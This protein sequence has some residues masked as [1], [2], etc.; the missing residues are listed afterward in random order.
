MRVDRRA[1][2]ISGVLVLVLTVSCFWSAANLAR[3][4][5]PAFENCGC[6]LPSPT[7]YVL[8]VRERPH[9][10][11]LLPWLAGVLLVGAGALSRRWPCADT[12]GLVALFLGPV[13]T[14]AFSAVALLQP[15]LSFALGSHPNT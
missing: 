9:S 5:M 3:L 11:L 8:D 14:L 10:Y 2:W 13:A 15:M 12:V 4:T 6:M 7:Q 1:E